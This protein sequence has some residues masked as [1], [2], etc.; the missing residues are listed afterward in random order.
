[1]A[2]TPSFQ[3]YT[4]DWMKDPQLSMCCPATRGIW[5]DLLCAMHES[6]RSGIVKGTLPQLARLARCSEA[7]MEAALCEL[8]ATN[9]AD[10]HFCPPEF[11]V[12][13]R[14]MHAEHKARQYNAEYKR[15]KRGK[16]DVRQKSSLHS[17]SSSSSSSSDTP[18]SP[19]TGGAAPPP[20]GSGPANPRRRRRRDAPPPEPTVTCPNPDCGLEQAEKHL[21]WDD[22]STPGWITYHCR[23]CGAEVSRRRADEEVAR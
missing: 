3:F 11:K 4:G 13:C 21:R 12:I 6:D 22:E 7:E 23:N 15:Q 19:P 5:M 9:T 2:K 20:N 10:V 16:G 8:K 14:R 1:M 17:S 18:L